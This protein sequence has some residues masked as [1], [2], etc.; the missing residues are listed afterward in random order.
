MAKPE[1]KHHNNIQHRLRG[2]HQLVAVS[3]RVCAQSLEP[4]IGVSSE[5]WE[6]DRRV[7][8]T[9]HCTCAIGIR[10]NLQYEQRERRLN[11]ATL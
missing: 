5:V 7:I 2:T 3:A 4:I 9:P 10:K 11:K 8:R 1:E 6:E